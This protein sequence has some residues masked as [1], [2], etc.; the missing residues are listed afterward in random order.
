M[1]TNDLLQL[2]NTSFNDSELRD[3]CFAMKVDYDDLSGEGKRAKVRELILYCVRHKHLPELIKLCQYERPLITWPD[4][5]QI[6]ILSVQH[7]TDHNRQVI[8]ERVKRFWIR[9]LLEKSLAHEVMIAL[10]L[11]NA[12]NTIDLPLNFQ[13]QE[14]TQ[15]PHIIHAGTPIIDIFT[16]F[17][18]TLLI[19]GAPGAG[20][21]TLLLELARDLISRA[22]LDPTHKIPVIFNLSSWGVK[23]APL[24]EWLVNELNT[25]YD[26]PIKIAKV[27]VKNDDLLPLLDGLDEVAREHR[28]TCVET[29]NTYRR[30]H[31]LVP[32][33]VCSREVDYE[34][35]GRKLRLRGAIAVQPLTRIQIAD[36]LTRFG[37]ALEGVHVVLERDEVLWEIL[38]TP[39]LLSIMTLAYRG[40]SADEISAGGTLDSQ[41]IHLFTA[42]TNAMFKR[43]SITTLYIKQQTTKRLASLARNMKQ[44]NQSLLFIEQLQSAWLSTPTR[45]WQ[46]VI[47]TGLLTGL[48]LGLTL[49]III[50]FG[51]KSNIGL[52][53]GIIFGLVRGIQCG[54]NAATGDI[55]SADKLQWSWHRMF[56]RLRYNIIR[57]LI[58]GIVCGLGSAL[59]SG[60]LIRTDHAFEV[61]LSVGLGGGLFIGLAFG[62]MNGWGSDEAIDRWMKPNQ[63][64]WQ[65]LANALRLGLSI[66]FIGALGGLFVGWL[67]SKIVDESFNWILIGLLSGL[68]GGFIDGWLL[69]GG[70][71]YLRHIILRFLLWRDNILPLNLIRFLDA[72]T[73]L[74]FLRKVGGGYIFIHRMLM[75]YFARLGED[76]MPRTTKGNNGDTAISDQ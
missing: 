36:Y 53:V 20:K 59:I 40:K 25:K 16:D 34:A 28:E 68:F 5:A 64:T 61:G 45:R 67:I 1:N 23:R 69:Y 24:T 14:W 26:I 74:I 58:L 39:L 33:V 9:G 72:G 15:Q 44:Q 2:I 37:V 62:L 56:S 73:N 13:I 22:E 19:I 55:R 43:R 12:S 21:T 57:S 76:S 4:I 8:L 70:E 31:G 63:G 41:R 71:M 30:E 27:W 51:V 52:G 75:E 32:L 60:L 54:I 38:K 10:D 48:C 66:S 7:K 47:G 11:E 49:G 6:Q 29:I 35:L 50:G 3:L 46:Y 17:D 18:S 65:S 42:Y